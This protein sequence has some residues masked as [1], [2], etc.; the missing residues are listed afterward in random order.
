MGVHDLNFFGRI[1]DAS[2]FQ[3][4]DLCPD[5]HRKE[6]ASPRCLAYT[7]LQILSVSIFEKIQLSCAFAGDEP[8]IEPSNPDK[9]LNLFEL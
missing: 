4:P 8:A 1:C 2:G 3:R 5:C 6:G 7:L 9:Q